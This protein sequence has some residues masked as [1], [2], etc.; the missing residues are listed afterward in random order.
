MATNLKI[1]DALLSEALKLSGFRTK[2]EAVNEALREF[3]ERRRQ[4]KVLKLAGKI[5]FDPSYD[6]KAQRKRA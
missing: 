2:R 3:V 5:E 6:Y 4:R 1:D